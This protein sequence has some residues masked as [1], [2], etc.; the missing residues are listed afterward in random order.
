M[1]SIRNP[2]S[3][4]K[5]PVT[6]IAQPIKQL[7]F[8]SK[9]GALGPLPGAHSSSGAADPQPVPTP[10]A[11]ITAANAEVLQAQNDFARAN[12][13]KKS[14]RKTIVAGDTGGFNPRA[15]NSPMGGGAPAGGYKARVG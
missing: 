5:N 13:L 14:V 7:P 2:L 11:P 10:A 9:S 12:L 8:E 15:Q 3:V 6:A 1:C 4:W